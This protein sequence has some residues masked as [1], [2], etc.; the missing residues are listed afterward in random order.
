MA[1]LA[2]E[3]S[4]G[5]IAPELLAS[6]LWAGDVAIPLSGVSSLIT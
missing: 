4:S 1:P 5:N 6:N 3:G 2:P